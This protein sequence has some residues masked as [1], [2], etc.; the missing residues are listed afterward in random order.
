MINVDEILSKLTLEEKIKIVVGVGM[1]G[2]LSNPQ[3][4]VAGVAG[5]THPVPRLGLQSAILADG[6]AGLRIN[7]VRE[8]DKNTY[9]VTAFP[10]AVMLASTWNRELLEEVGK[11]MGE[12]VREYGV[13]IL[14]APAM[15][16]HRNPLCGRNF[17]YYSED[18]LLSGEM[19]AA[20][21]KGVQSQ[22]V[23][24]CP[25]HFAA[26][27]Q[28]TNRMSVDTIVSERALR[29]IYLRGFEIAVKKSKPWTIMSAY[30]KLNGTYC[31]QNRWLLTKVLREEWGFE[32]FVMTDWYAGIDPVEQLKAGNDLIMPG[33]VN[34]VNP[35]RKDEIGEITEAVK[36]GKLSEE[37]LNECVRNILKVLVNSPSFQN[38][39]YSN[40]PDLEAHAK[41]AYKAGVEGAVLL[42]NE[43]VLP[44]DKG[45]KIAVFGTGQIET[46]KGGTGSGDTHPRYTIF[47]LEAMRKLG[48]KV[49]EELAASYE[50]YIKRMRETEDYKPVQHPWGFL[51]YPKLS[52][53]FLSEQEIKKLAQRNDLAVI[54]ISRISGEGDDRKAVKGDFYL[55]DD[56]LKL[57]QK[58][59]EE[60]HKAGKKVVVLLN[61]G[62]PIEMIS[63]RD[64]VDGIL[65]IWQAGQETGRIAAD[66]LTGE[67]N[68][69]GKLPTTFPKDYSDV[70]SWNFPGEPK[71]N[72]DTV[73]YEEDIYIGYRY[74]DTFGVEPAY[75]FGYGLFYTKFQ[76]SDLKVSLDGESVKISY[77]ITNIGERSGKEISQ[78]YVKSPKGKIGK[79]LQELKAFHKTKLLNP[80]DREEILIEVPLRDL[81]SFDKEEWVLEKGEYEVRV[82]ASSKDIRLKATFVLNKE[83]RFLP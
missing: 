36:E 82:G 72:P 61:I 64:F 9:Y 12:E 74:Y 70:P 11:A 67:V 57:I 30:N 32:G 40:T 24:A 8:N 28:E 79:P 35:F 83:R 45:A 41:I 62:S 14:L 33:K 47:I 49:D 65:L 21:V 75:E 15:N 68:P 19:A 63:W 26:N 31:S 20:F 7:P 37:V 60:F 51:V 34:Q 73:I 2:L 77:S 5:E 16:I 27:N 54:V 42:K 46:I 22:R 17:E 18:P 39:K 71:D 10:V 6:P 81:A 29:E 56:E 52:E 44:I 13:D 23:G 69:S 78:V 55:S 38:Y 80:Q 58:I 43:K 66:L 48:L 3:S 76:Y 59:A 1:P 50:N 53:D 25:K 4:R